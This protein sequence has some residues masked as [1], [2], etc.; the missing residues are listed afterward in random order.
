MA[1]RTSTTA[2]QQEVVS[3]YDSGLTQSQIA[4]RLGVKPSTARKHIIAY[5]RNQLI[6]AGHDVPSVEA[7][8]YGR[9]APGNRGLPSRPHLYLATSDGLEIDQPT[10]F[11]PTP[12]EG[13]GDD[14][15]GEGEEPTPR[16]V[17]RRGGLQVERRRRIIRWPHKGV[18]T[19]IVTSAQD[20]VAVHERFLRNLEAYRDWAGD[21]G[22]AELI[23]AGYTYNKG[24]SQSAWDKSDPVFLD[25]GALHA[26]DDRDLRRIVFF[27][28]RV[29]SYWADHRIELDDRLDIAG[30]MN[31]IPTA[32]TPLS[33]LAAYTGP[34]WGVFPHAKQQLESIPRLPGERYKA[35]L[36]TGSCT[37]PSYIARKAGLKAEPHHM[38]GAAII[39]CLPDGTTFCRTITADAETGDFYDLDR[40]VVG[41]VVTE[42][43]R[44]SAIA[45]GDIHHEKIDPDV[46]AATWGYFP[47]HGTIVPSWAKES[48]FERLRP[49][50]Q[51]FHDLSDFAPR[52]HHNVAD[53][54]FMI[55]THWNGACNVAHELK[56]CAGF[57]EATRRDWC[58][59]VVVQSNHDN[60]FARW[61]RDAD[62][63]RDP[64]N[65]P[66]YLERASKVARHIADKG[67]EPPIFEI[68]L[69]EMSEDHLKGVAFV[70]EDDSFV[71]HG[72]EHSQHGHLGPN[73]AR[74]SALGL[75]R[76]AMP[77]TIGHGHAPAIRDGLFMSGA[78]SLEMG[79]NKGPTGWAIAHTILH[80][81]GARQM[82]FYDGDA[83]HA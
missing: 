47:E 60:A 50:H 8:L 71:V 38:L 58:K 57:L 67:T 55:A 81:D 35:N 79:Y 46:A 3:L 53:P 34:R 61:L 25:A 75:S 12:S 26:I 68:T 1:N 44:V 4:R 73:G 56:R 65:A 31:T 7:M 41:G 10:A 14:G 11:D 36:T 43:H 70:S 52:N 59:S 48:L 22:S 69:R 42:G 40:R 30:E 17:F 18:L 28:S 39:E 5:R 13:P 82:L 66:F 51:F 77:L 16:D 74:G 72:V 32:V 23:V 21:R 9:I 54:F 24:M 64:E 15:E 19:L 6:A 33:G 83:F 63:K 37:P 62:W 78:C 27:D 45:Y 49:E 2:R 76:M 80:Q 20:G 29:E